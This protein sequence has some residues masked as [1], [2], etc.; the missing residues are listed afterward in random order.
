MTHSIPRWGNEQR[1]RKAAMVLQTLQHFAGFDLSSARGTDIGC[2]GGGIAAYLAD[3]LQQMTGI[4][5]EPWP[6]WP[7]LMQQ[8]LNLKL[9]QGSYDSNPLPAGSM[10]IV[11][12]NQVYEHV[13]DPVRLIRFIHEVLRPGGVAYFAGPN[14]LFP[15][16]PH[17]LWPFVHWLPRRFAVALMRACGS[18]KVLDANSASYWT[19]QNWLK[20]FEIINA[21]PWMLRNPHSVGRRNPAWHLPALF[22]ARLLDALTF[23]SPGFVFV[24]VKR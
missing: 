4:D 5:P 15:I 19:L 21:V 10:D 14:L 3:H 22:P 8:H 13:S 24:L 20:E 12:C 7:E 11:V 9:L 18:H 17:T 16:E 6:Q 23:L 1:E 2:G